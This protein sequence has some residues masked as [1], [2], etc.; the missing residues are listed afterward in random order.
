MIIQLIGKKGSDSVLIEK[1]ATT[2]DIYRASDFN[3]DGFDVFTVAVPNG[4]ETKN[5]TSN[6]VYTPTA[7][8]IGFS[9]VTVNV[10]YC[11]EKSKDVN[12]KLVSGGA[13]IIDLNGATDIGDYVLA[14]AYLDN[15]AVSGLVDFSSLTAI[16]GTMACYQTFKNCTGLTGADLSSVVI[17]SGDQACS[18]TFDSCV[19]MTS[20]DLSALTTISGEEGCWAMF[21]NCTR[22][23][24]VLLSSLSSITG[25]RACR[26]M[27]ANTGLTS[28]S[29][30]ALTSNS[31]GSYTNQFNEMLLSVTGC[32]V[33][34]P[35]NLQSVIG[36]W[37]DVIDGF[38]GT[39]TT[40]LFDLPAT[41]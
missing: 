31:F 3:A 13:S 21:I 15:S 17:I 18:S 12:N 22:L 1:T 34:F 36:S 28:L 24:S 20:A 41:E 40:V 4:T 25:A 39:N 9:S 30:P 32:T 19:A 2:N 27:F 37:Q 5:I 6:G 29:F 38:G 10:P 16:T 14:Y 23:T 35:S 11:V 7:P 33:H 26:R 8:N